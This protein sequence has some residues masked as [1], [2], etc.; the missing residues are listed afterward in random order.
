VTNALLSPTNDN[1][2]YLQFMKVAAE[3][4][5]EFKD[6]LLAESRPCTPEV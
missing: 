5:L 6:Y 2:K 4:E 1:D 3:M